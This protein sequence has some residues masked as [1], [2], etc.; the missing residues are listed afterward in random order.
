MK[1]KVGKEED[2]KNKKNR[3]TL[4]DVAKDR[5]I[6]SDKNGTSVKVISK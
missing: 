3:E 5:M 6:G 2:S 4:E 1:D